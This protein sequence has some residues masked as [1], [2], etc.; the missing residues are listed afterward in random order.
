MYI[1]DMF[2]IMENL[3]QSWKMSYKFIVKIPSLSYKKEKYK[4]LLLCEI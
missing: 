1:W 2:Y 3:G 4:L